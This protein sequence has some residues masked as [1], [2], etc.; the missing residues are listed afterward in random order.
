MSISKKEVNEC[1]RKI[2][3]VKKEISKAVVGQK[4]VINSILRG[5]LSNGHMLVEG[6]PGIAKTLIVRIISQV[7]G[8]SFSRIQFTPDLL[9]SDIIG[10][11]AYD[12]RKGFYTVK[13]PIFAHFILADEINRAPPKV[14]SALLEAMQERQVTIG[15]KSFKLNTP[16]FVLATENPLEQLGTY[17]LP[18]AQL[19]RF[20]FKIFINYPSQEE[21]LIILKENINLKNIED[22]NIKNILSP[23]EIIE[24]QETTKKIYL[25]PKIEKY[26]VNIVDT[27]RNHAHQDIMFKNFIRVGS[28]PRGAIGLFIASKAHALIEGRTFVTP[29]DVKQVAPDVLR[30][31]IILNYEGIAENISTDTIIQEILKKTK[32]P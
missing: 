11:T 30:H 1:Q 24:L 19:D 9:P 20:L 14:Q 3:Q 31:R 29:H 27:T 12:P 26:I 25:D 23:Q 10:I 17:S 7:M 2:S 13:G 5:I 15:K 18:E 8:I 22:F 16:F 28:S 6:Y 21:E 4:D 32:I